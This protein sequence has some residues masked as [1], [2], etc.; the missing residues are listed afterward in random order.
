MTAGELSTMVMNQVKWTTE[1]CINNGYLNGSDTC[2]HM[3]RGDLPEGLC[4]SLGCRSQGLIGAVCHDPKGFLRPPGVASGVPPSAGSAISVKNIQS[5]Y[6]MVIVGF[7]NYFPFSWFFSETSAP[8][9]PKQQETIGW[10]LWT[11]QHGGEYG[12]KEWWPE[13]ALQYTQYCPRM[14]RWKDLQVPS[15]SMYRSCLQ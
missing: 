7:W 2:R 8:N 15:E 14:C 1:P 5:W 4:K 10:T 3:A 9:T 13:I 12:W 6:V 11:L